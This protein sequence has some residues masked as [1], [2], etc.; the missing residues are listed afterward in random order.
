MDY[1]IEELTSGI[2][3]G[4]E[5]P[6]GFNYVTVVPGSEMNSVVTEYTIRLN[7]PS[8][9][10]AG[11]VLRVGFPETVVLESGVTCSLPC[12]LESEGVLVVTLPLTQGDAEVVVTVANVRNPP[13]MKPSGGFVFET[14]A[15][16]LVSKYSKDT[17]K[18]VTTS[19]ASGIATA[20]AEFSVRYYGG[21]TELTLSFSPV[22]GEIGRIEVNINN[23]FR[24][25]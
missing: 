19:V 12:V 11:G 23:D 5:E 4:V 3:T 7:Q 1:L 16:D 10:E 13:S 18:F 8:E 15:A 17:S 25:Q 9:I 21:E 14:F 22:H 2:T 24:V 6:T 20:D